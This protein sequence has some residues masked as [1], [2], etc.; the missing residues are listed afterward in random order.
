MHRRNA[1]A[2][3]RER[4]SPGNDGAFSAGRA[5]PASRLSSGI[6]CGPART[7]STR[8]TPADGPGWYW[9]SRTSRYLETADS[10]WS[11]G[12]RDRSLGAAAP[13]GFASRGSKTGPM[14]I[15]GDD[16]TW[17]TL[18]RW[19]KLRCS[20]PGQ[21]ARALAI[22]CDQARSSSHAARLDAARVGRSRIPMRTLDWRSRSL[23]RPNPERHR[24][25]QAR[26]SAVARCPTIRA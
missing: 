23:A 11:P 7:G 25:D 19:Q 26:P 18:A 6:A 22:Q 13:A 24:G 20:W 16:D 1:D 21:R 5:V 9:T 2:M 8:R 17:L 14:P 12:N 15:G 4:D 10:R 3:R